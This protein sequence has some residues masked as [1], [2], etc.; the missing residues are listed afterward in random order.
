MR[1]VRRATRAGRRGSTGPRVRVSGRPGPVLDART[2]DGEGVTRAQAAAGAVQRAAPV[3]IGPVTPPPRAHPCTSPMLPTT[4]FT[5]FRRFAPARLVRTLVALVALCALLPAHAQ[6][7]VDQAVLEFG[8]GT[9]TRD[10]EVGN[11]GD[12][13]LYLDM[14]VAEI[15]EPHSAEPVRRE[16]DD[17]R[18]APVVVS[19]KQVLL[20]PGARKR[21]RVIMR[22]RSADED[23]VFRLA[24]KPYTGK[25][26]VNGADPDARAS[27]VKVLVG[28]DLLV[29]SR[30]SEPEPKLDV[31]R[32][33]GAIEF[34]N[35]G[36]TNIL[37]RDIRQC[38]AS[39]PDDC[40]ELEPNRL[41]V[42]ETYRVELPRRGPAE[43][44]PVRVL[45]SVGLDSARE[46]Y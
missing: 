7:T 8:D 39:V 30:P 41:Y 32:T 37:L 5:L 17:P 26:N 34:R 25:V 15:L 35:A 27:A 42:G 45:R 23:R 13:P 46:M 33:D 20:R 28:Y 1:D 29:L 36:N 19:P 11:S 24:I 14:S 21:L 43:R 3:P 38:D 22:E 16:F 2:G 9:R 44:Y 31:T 18:T 4:P 40:V 10:I 6:L 12:F